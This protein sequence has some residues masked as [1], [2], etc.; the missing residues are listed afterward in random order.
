M[1]SFNGKPLIERQID[2]FRACGINDIVVVRKH[3]AEKIIIPGVKYINETDYDTHMVVG[4]FRAREEFDDD[5]ILSYG[6][7]IFEQRV[8]RAAIDARVDVGVVA[9]YEWKDYWTARCGDWRMDS[10][11]FVIGESDKL[12][13][14]GISNPPE[15]KMHARYVGMIKFSK[16]IL[17]GVAEMYDRAQKE[18]WERPWYTSKSFK[19]AYMTDFVQALIDQKIDVRVVGIRRGWLEFDTVADYEL[20]CDWLKANKLNS[21]I[22]LGK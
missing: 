12:V 14:L 10:E 16:N 22:V 3:L 6:D 20:A 18:F 17:A 19:K 1:L 4:F 9:D 11:S 15:D 21:F 7:I 13:S 8:L 2:T 5:I